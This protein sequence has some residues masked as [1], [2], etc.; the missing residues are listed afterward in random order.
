MIQQEFGLFSTL[1]AGLVAAFAGGLAAR[2]AKLP[3]LLGYI[4]AGLFIGPFAPGYSANQEMANELA[5]VGVA[6]LLFNIGLHFS[7]KDL[8]RV[9][10]IVVPGALAQVFLTTAIGAGIAWLVLDV[11]P[12]TSIVIGLS[13]AIASTAIVTRN[14]DERRQLN[15]VAGRI[16]MGWLVVQDLIVIMALVFLPIMGSSV[17][18]TF[19]DLFAA[20][21]QTFLQITGFVFVMMVVGR[22][23]IP[24]L[25]R[26]VARIG[27]RE[28]FTLA[29]I[30]IALGIA[31]GSSMI[32]GVS[33]ALGAFFAGVVIGESD[34]NL[35]AASEALSMQQVFT[36][37]FFVSVGMLFDPSSFFFM[38]LQIIAFLLAIVLGMGL[39]TF[40]ILVFF[41]VPLRS[42]LLI[43]ASFSQIGEFSF[44]L[45]ELCF[46]NE[47]FG[48]AERDIIV[49]VAILSIFVNP[50]V[51]LSVG[52]IEKWVARSV[53]LN[54]WLSSHGEV[55]FPET[56][57]MHDHT[58][59][60]GHGHVGG[61]LASALREHGL[62]YICIESN[63]NVT[64]SARKEGAQ[65]IYGDAS[66]DAVL[67]AAHPE[68]AR[69]MVV[70]TA[71]TFSAR[72]IVRVARKNYPDL[73]IVVR[74]QSDEEALSM[75]KLGVG[76]AIMGER[77]VAFGFLFYVLQTL[78]LDLDQTSTTITHLRNE[79]YSLD[80]K[81]NVSA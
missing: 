8:L 20:L 78:G 28:L 73:K 58:I 21:A 25:L 66:R 30:V 47:I 18:G 43:G 59:L 23:F 9:K 31:Y 14:M 11:L 67:A 70:S 46:K 74:T 50:L 55:V 42:A 35:H 4:L 49:A 44:V 3:P 39:L 60:V 24:V 56:E 54:Q 53:W 72:Q 5:E 12:R 7:F 1:V 64:E 62:P 16:A 27:S 80:K 10:K 38:P 71:D 51:F 77:E 15:T 17:K 40:I 29:V 13:L 75:T 36:I 76:F 19:T 6:L 48:S 37:L 57:V 81:E 79:I 52:K 63:R 2:S 26:Y 45:S 68:S 32:F 22:R 34:L 65:V 33:L 69:L 41:R 61:I